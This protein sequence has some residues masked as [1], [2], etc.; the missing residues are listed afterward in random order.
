M[1]HIYI[2]LFATF[3]FFSCK[4]NDIQPTPF[5][6][7]GALGDITK[8]ISE[9]PLSIS[10]IFAE[11][12]SDITSFLTLK[13]NITAYVV[14][15]KSQNKDGDTVIASGIII[16]PSTENIAIPLLSYQHGT[17][18]PK[19]SAP[20]IH[21][22]EEYKLNLALSS[23]KD[24]VT[25]IPDYLGLG[26]GEGQHLYLN[27]REEANSVRD[28]LRAARK[29]VKQ[30]QST[31]LNGQVFLYGYSQGGHATMAAQRQLELENSNEFKLTASAPMAGPYAMSRTSQF[32]VMLDSIYYP[33][34]FY[35]PYLAVSLFK[36]YP[37]YASYSQLFKSPF[38]ARIPVA[39][40]GYHSYSYANS[41]FDY[42]VSNII[43]DSVKAN[44]RT[45]PNHPI[46]LACKGYDLVDDWT[47]TTPMRLYHC[48]GDDNVY[49]DNAVY[50]DSVFRARGADVEL[51]NLGSDNHT[52]C[53]PTAIFVTMS[54]F[55]GLFEYT[56]IK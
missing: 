40:D 28:I 26:T 41:Q 14:E 4:Q 49:Y 22:G 54:W 55:S 10:D 53:A 21:K 47:P 51:V 35:L 27:P 52:D 30:K 8:I 33:N 29:L 3:L 12:P 17:I 23:S 50:A 37:L 46:R 7:D 20:S 1:R 44:I 48:E 31:A 39:I 9:T 15:Y 38:D 34:P 16:I 11:L 42:Y 2:F 56:K 43:L 45:N 13:S 6:Y 24:V 36:T 19:N 18:L 32:N 5:E 25:C